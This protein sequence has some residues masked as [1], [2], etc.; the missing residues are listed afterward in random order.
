MSGRVCK[1]YCDLKNIA[2]SGVAIYNDSFWFVNKN[3]GNMFRFFPQNESTSYIGYYEELTFDMAGTF[4][5][6][7]R[8]FFVA[9]RG[10]HIV[11]VSLEDNSPTVERTYHIDDCF[12]VKTAFLFENSIVIISR[13]TEEQIYVFDTDTED[14]THFSLLDCG[15]NRV[16]TY[17]CI[18]A[19]ADGFGYSLFNAQDICLVDIKTKRIDKILFDEDIQIGGFAIRHDEIWV[20]N[21]RNGGAIQYNMNT[22]EYVDY[23]V[24]DASEMERVDYGRIDILGDKIIIK[25]LKS[26]TIYYIDFSLRCLKK[27]LINDERLFDERKQ[28]VSFSIGGI[29]YGKHYYLF[30]WALPGLIDIS[31]N[32][33]TAR[34]HVHRLSMEDYRILFEKKKRDILLEDEC[35]MDVNTYLRMIV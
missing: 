9:N 15:E 3:D 17:Q 1:E 24:H 23:L 28:D 26:N 10:V 4:V 13:Q 35:M 31:L 16:A 34:M 27:I 11:S 18:S 25:P 12:C 7:A 30:P 19:S 20:K 6:G 29:N 33:M 14:F 22:K 32:N 21:C 5:I 8:A 2:Y